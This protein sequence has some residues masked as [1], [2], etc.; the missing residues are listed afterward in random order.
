[1]SNRNEFYDV[2]DTI[3]NNKRTE[4]SCGT[5]GS[6]NTEY[7]KL[8]CIEGKL[9]KYILEFKNKQYKEQQLVDNDNINITQLNILLT[10][11]NDIFLR[12]INT[13][14]IYL[15]YYQ[16][17]SDIDRETQRVARLILKNENPAN[18]G[19]IY[20]I[21]RCQYNI[22]EVSKNLKEIQ[23]YKKQITS[24][25]DYISSMQHYKNSVDILILCNYI[26]EAIKKI[27]D[28]I[29]ALP[30]LPIKN[31]CIN[32]TDINGKRIHTKCSGDKYNDKYLV[33]Y[34][35][36]QVN[37][38]IIDAI[39]ILKTEKIYQ[40]EKKGKD[41][42]IEIL[43]KL[44]KNIL[45]KDHHSEIE[46]LYNDLQQIKTFKGTYEKIIDII[47]YLKT[48]DI[49]HDIIDY[50]K[51]VDLRYIDI[52]EP[53]IG[54]EDTRSLNIPLRLKIE[55]LDLILNYK[56]LIEMEQKIQKEQKFPIKYYKIINANKFKVIF[57]KL[58]KL[59]TENEDY[60][61]SIILDM[62]I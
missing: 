52:T 40:T 36:E 50:F 33:Y 51:L 39:K 8:T 48:I 18:V 54:I 19:Y 23:Y 27:I 31:I 56:G 29:K 3:N 44:K 41:S 45:F 7:L 55:A 13:I 47:K 60:K 61:K 42:I 12:I 58:D 9:L 2:L 62:K 25:N 20:E 43:E 59:N 10:R 28:K 24:Y 30:S 14:N 53:E 46:R 35:I 17:S 49:K 5:L 21:Q 16:Q 32:G 37:K 4:Y 38:Y 1:M 57:D 11:V 34:S 26:T 15:K 6:N 22:D